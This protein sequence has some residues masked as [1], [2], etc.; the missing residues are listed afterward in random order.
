MYASRSISQN[1]LSR[2]DTQVSCHCSLK[3]HVRNVPHT[4][5]ELEQAFGEV[6]VAVLTKQM[7]SAIKYMHD[8]GVAHRDIK[9]VC[10]RWGEF[11]T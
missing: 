1:R 3:I 6:R 5:R 11:H 2:P 8:R 10:R 7:L 9:R 4:Y